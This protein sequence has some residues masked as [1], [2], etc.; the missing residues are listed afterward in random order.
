[1]FPDNLILSQITQPIFAL[2]I[3]FLVV[4]FSFIIFTIVV[5][6]QLNVM[7]KVVEEV[8]TSFVLEVAAAINIL[9]AISLF[10]LAL[11][12]L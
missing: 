4:I 12:I 11:V 7:N 10:L 1:M 8:H 3:I 2:K 5:F 6:T 9:L